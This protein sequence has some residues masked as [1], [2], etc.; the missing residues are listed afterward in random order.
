MPIINTGFGQVIAKGFRQ[1]IEIDREKFLI[2]AR[3][4]WQSYERSKTS[5]QLRPKFKV[6][7]DY[8]AYR[9]IDVGY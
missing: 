8:I 5:K 1:L 2:N 9:I 4:F 7:D 3:R 6:Y